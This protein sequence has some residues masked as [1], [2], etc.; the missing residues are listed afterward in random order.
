MHPTGMLSSF[1]FFYKLKIDLSNEFIKSSKSRFLSLFVN[2]II[3]RNMIDVA[4]S[5]LFREMVNK[6]VSKIVK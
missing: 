3:V 6:V 1:S 4:L 5:C 2:K